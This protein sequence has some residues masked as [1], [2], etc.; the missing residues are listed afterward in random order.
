MCGPG[1]YDVKIRIGYRK[2]RAHQIILRT[3]RFVEPIE[4]FFQIAGSKAL[5][6]V[7]GRRVKERPEILMYFRIDVGE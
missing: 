3:Q 5:N 1:E 7:T 4:P 2:P 6:V